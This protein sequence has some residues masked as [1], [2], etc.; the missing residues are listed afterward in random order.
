MKNHKG[1]IA[2][3][4]TLG[5][6][7]IGTLVTLG[8]SLFVSNQKT[9]LASNSRA[10]TGVYHACSIDNPAYTTGGYYICSGKYYKVSSC[11]S[12][13]SE[14]VGAYCKALNPSAG[15]STSLSGSSQSAAGVDTATSGNP[16]VS[17]ICPENSGITA[18][19]RGG[20]VYKYSGCGQTG[21]LPYNQI[22]YPP[23]G[24]LGGTGDAGLVLCKYNYSDA[25]AAKTMCSS[26][27]PPQIPSQVGCTST[28]FKCIT[29]PN[30]SSICRT[31]E[32]VNRLCSGNYI[33]SINCPSDKKYKCLA[34]SSADGSLVVN[35]Q[36]N[37]SDSEV[38]GQGQSCCFQ[39]KG[40]VYVYS[41]YQSMTNNE[42]SMNCKGMTKSFVSSYQ[43]DDPPGGFVCSGGTANLTSISDYN[44][45]NPPKGGSGGSQGNLTV[46]EGCNSTNCKTYFGS[47]GVNFLSTVLISTNKSGATAYYKSGNCADGTKVNTLAELQKYCE[48]ES[49]AQSLVN[50]SPDQSCSGKYGAAANSNL[51]AFSIDSSNTTTFYKGNSCYGTEKTNEAGIKTYC[52]ED[53]KAEADAKCSENVACTTVGST[54]STTK[55]SSKTFSGATHYY[56]STDCS[57]T[58]VPKD[59]AKAYCDSQIPPPIGGNLN[60]GEEITTNDG[61]NVTYENCTYETLSSSLTDYAA[62]DNKC[63]QLYGPTHKIL[64]FNGYFSRPY[65][66]CCKGTK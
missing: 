32:D 22:C 3:L 48:T 12:L 30:L 37:G 65:T 45:A 39:K 24:G 50:C 64:E 7:V 13:I 66:Y 46:P 61:T 36:A 49:S 23:A 1:A 9:N 2:T 44:A 38:V 28:S 54:N 20:T 56:Q 19:K 35:G 51:F 17:F 34:S 27:N 42:M 41:T 6:V 29:D 59:V 43:A 21:A 11:S 62:Y 8:T 4:L 63:E 15:S 16:C 26:S 60:I 33:T 52:T 18:Y 14:G 5:L 53:P 10:D 25:A 58:A 57:D 31:L 40:K 55:I 47:N